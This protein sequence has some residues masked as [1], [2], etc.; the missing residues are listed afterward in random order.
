MSPAFRASHRPCYTRASCVTLR[1]RP[2]SLFELRRGLAVAL[3]SAVPV[4]RLV[5]A[6]AEEADTASADLLAFAKGGSAI[7]LPRE[8]SLDFSDRKAD[9]ARTATR[10]LGV[11]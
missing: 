3:R 9:A 4:A 2:T 7:S 5:R 11:D 1:L 8:D 6:G 10:S